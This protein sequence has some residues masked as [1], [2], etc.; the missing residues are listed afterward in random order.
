[1][2]RSTCSGRPAASRARSRCRASTTSRS[3]GCSATTTTRSPPSAG[4]GTD[5]RTA[6]RERS[7]EP[8]AAPSGGAGLMHALEGVRLIDLGQ[9]RAGPF[10]PMIIGAL[11]AGFIKVEPVTG[12]GMRLAGKPFFGCQ[13]GKRAIALDLKN[14]TGVEIALQLV[15]KADIVHHNM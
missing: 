14:P 6:E 5:E 2:C 10:G 7:A 1:G 12:D 3:S 11:G 13:R 8:E 4:R 15:A 9:Y